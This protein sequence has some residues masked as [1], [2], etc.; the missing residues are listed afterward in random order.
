LGRKWNEKV[1][2]QF[3]VML[4]HMPGRAEENNENLSG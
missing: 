2:V 1:V 3:T 4:Q